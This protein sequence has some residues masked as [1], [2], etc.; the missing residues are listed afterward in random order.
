MINALFGYVKKAVEL[1]GKKAKIR[2]FQSV[3]RQI[4]AKITCF[5]KIGMIFANYVRFGRCFFE[6]FKKMFF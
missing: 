1:L 6:S 5:F 4:C 3:I 2:L